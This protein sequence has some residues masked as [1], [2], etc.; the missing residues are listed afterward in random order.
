MSRGE[1]GN[2]AGLHRNRGSPNEVERR[3]RR[4]VEVKVNK[5]EAPLP[6][7]RS[8]FAWARDPEWADGCR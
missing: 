3:G 2:G 1:L 5:T 6:F 7:A 4:A 8:P